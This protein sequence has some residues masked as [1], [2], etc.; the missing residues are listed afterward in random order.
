[1][2]KYMLESQGE[3]VVLPI[4][5]A[6]F[7]MPVAGNNYV[8]E[9]V[10]L[11]EIVVP[12]KP[13]LFISP[14]ESIF[15]YD[16]EFPPKQFVDFINRAWLTKKP[17]RFLVT[18][19]DKELMRVV[20]KDFQ[21][22]Y[23]AGQHRDIYFNLQLIEY[24]PYGAMRLQQKSENTILPQTDLRTNE[25]KPEVPKVYKTTEGETVISVTEKLT[26]N[27]EKWTEL[28][29]LN[30]QLIGNQPN[31]AANTSLDIPEGWRASGR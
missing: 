2:V 4:N 1:M 20:I 18:G 10:S 16:P 15:P 26:S 28:Y 29:D 11:G 19:L 12:R 14:I 17:L 8:T 21:H 5:P 30:K 31:L 6:K 3:I 22:D 24:V 13:K 9:I 27:S 25:N 23:R 7:D